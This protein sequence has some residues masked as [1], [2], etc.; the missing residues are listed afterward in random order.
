V[1][2]KLESTP[3]KRTPSASNLLQSSPSS[4][5]GGGGS[6]A[7]V[8]GGQLSASAVAAATA[9]PATH[10][11]TFSMSNFF[12]N[13]S[14]SRNNSANGSALGASA[15]GASASTASGNGPPLPSPIAITPSPEPV[16]RGSYNAF[17]SSGSSA[18]PRSSLDD[19]NIGGKDKDRDSS[20]LSKVFH[21]HKRRGSDDSGISASSSSG[22]G[23]AMG[24]PDSSTG[25]LTAGSLSNAEM[26]NAG[27]FNE[28]E[29]LM[30][31][32]YNLMDNYAA[33]ICCVFL[34]CNLIESL[35][36]LGINGPN[37]I[38]KKSRKLMVIFL[39]TLALIFPEQLCS[40]LLTIP[41]LIE[42]AASVLS[43]KSVKRVHKSS[44]VLIALAEAFT[45]MPYKKISG[46]HISGL[47]SASHAA[48]RGSTSGGFSNS[49]MVGNAV[50]SSTSSLGGGAAAGAASAAS[51]SAA[52]SAKP[53]TPGNQSASSASASSVSA[54]VTAR[55]NIPPLNIQTVFELAEEIKISSFSTIS[56]GEDT[57]DGTRSVVAGAGGSSTQVEVLHNLRNNL[58]PEIDKTDFGKQLDQSKV[59]GREVPNVL[60]FIIVL[61]F[62]FV[63]TT[64]VTG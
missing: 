52:A 7:S 56:S 48:R 41:S 39:R 31:P 2:S 1:L 14:K 8:S 28:P 12:Q 34:H 44:Q 33:L 62:L 43:A 55:A 24:R 9:S 58:T 57:A 29:A 50:T 3:P 19:S 36:F 51:S 20:V 59:I 54:A 38:A 13:N 46:N 40:D 64:C 35:Y 21:L 53:S 5:T 26:R 45:V 37:S 11:K 4:S 23:V 6:L 61:V 63:S 47:T 22:G 17:N 18:L 16:R 15:G 60:Y 32:I 49:S 30:D 27:F 10:R 42:F 25:G